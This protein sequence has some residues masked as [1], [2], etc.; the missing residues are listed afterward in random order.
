MVCV[1]A[2]IPKWALPEVNYAA[3]SSIP[4]DLRLAD[5]LDRDNIVQTMF[6]DYNAQKKEFVGTKWPSTRLMS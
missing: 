2:C 4:Q 1:S 3:K 6:E 5:L